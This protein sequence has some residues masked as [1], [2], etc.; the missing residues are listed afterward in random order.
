MDMY[1]LNQE[2]AI[3]YQ[4]ILLASVACQFIVVVLLLKPLKKWVI[5]IIGL[6]LDVLGYRVRKKYIISFILTKIFSFLF[7]SLFLPTPNLHN[8]LF[9]LCSFLYVFLSACLS[10]FLSGRLRLPS[11]CSF[12]GGFSHTSVSSSSSCLFF[13][14][15]CMPL[16]LVHTIVYFK[17]APQYVCLSVLWK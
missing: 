14:L 5:P 15:F 12:L 3:L 16:L 9:F 6:K 13:A 8:R 10:F 11:S 17:H 4:G 2:D 1:G 7:F